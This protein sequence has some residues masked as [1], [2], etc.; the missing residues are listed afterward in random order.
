MKKVPQQRAT[1]GLPTC[2]FCLP[3]YA[4]AI[5]FLSFEFL[6]LEALAILGG[7]IVVE[8]AVE[9]ARTIILICVLVFLSIGGTLNALFYRLNPER[10]NMRAFKLMGGIPLAIY[11]LLI[12]LSLFLTLGIG[13]SPEVIVQHVHNIDVWI[14]KFEGHV[15]GVLLGL[16]GLCLAYYG[17]IFLSFK[18]QPG[19]RMVQ[20][21]TA[22]DL[23]GAIRIGEAV[24]QAKRDFLTN[25]NLA[26][27]YAQ[28]GR[29]E[30]AKVILTLLEQSTVV[31]RHFTAE[32]A[33]QAINNVKQTIVKHDPENQT[34]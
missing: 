16:L 29:I 28:S 8:D 9:N 21:V 34:N 31:P 30:E 3:F 10:F 11:S 17:Y 24:P 6:P 26:L 25:V 15:M 5:L 12:G 2:I 4:L 18:W 20:K 13:I 23:G 33:R 22:G 19:N 14:S 27:L 7:K 32:S 1:K